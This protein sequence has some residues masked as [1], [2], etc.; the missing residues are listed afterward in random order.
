M[1]EWCSLGRR[2]AW[3]RWARVI[4][5]DF[6]APVEP[7]PE[8]R[9]ERIGYKSSSSSCRK[10]FRRTGIPKIN[11]W[12]L[13]NNFLLYNLQ[14]KDSVW[15]RWSRTPLSFAFIWPE[16]VPWASGIDYNQ[17]A[18]QLGFFIFLKKFSFLLILGIDFFVSGIDSAIDSVIDFL[19]LIM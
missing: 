15:T 9:A 10:G 11:C 14:E 7:P 1:G 6:G 16:K 8:K 13:N 3:R 4:D 17:L 18:L 2:A 5:P 19:V 12:G